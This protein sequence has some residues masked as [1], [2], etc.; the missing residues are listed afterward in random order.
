MIWPWVNVSQS[1]EGS[2]PKSSYPTQIDL[3]TFKKEKENWEFAHEVMT[4]YLE[5]IMVW[6]WLKI[7]Y[8]IFKELLQYYFRKWGFIGVKV[9]GGR[10]T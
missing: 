10:K 7:L 8:G 3:M 1:R 5:A 9:K 6:K 4:V 2:I